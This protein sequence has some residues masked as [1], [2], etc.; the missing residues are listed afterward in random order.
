MKFATLATMLTTA[1][2]ETGNDHIA[3]MEEEAVAEKVF[4]VLAIV[5][6]IGVAACCLR[7]EVLRQ[8]E[9][10]RVLFQFDHDLLYQDLEPVDRPSWRA[11][12][13]RWMPISAPVVPPPA[14]PFVPFEIEEPDSIRA[15]N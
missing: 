1:N 7:R 6:L 5:V 3:G 8:R 15:T 2:N 10:R 9:N 14:N 13:R 4:I 11:R 12:L